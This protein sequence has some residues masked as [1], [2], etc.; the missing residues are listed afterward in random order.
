MSRDFS[1]QV[2]WITGG[3]S[4]IGRA[5]ALELGRRGASVAVSG[6]RTDRLAAVVGELE[7]AGA[8]ALAVACDVCAEDQIEAAVQAVVD[9]FGKLDVAVASA[10]FSVAGKVADLKAA[11]WR[12]QL[13]TNVIGAALTARHA[14]PHLRKTGG[15]I[16]LIG[17]VVSFLCQPKLGAYSA[18]KFALRAIGQTLALE[19]HG[20]GV[21]CTTIHPGFVDS[22]IAKVDNA[23]QFDPTRTDR[24]PQKLMWSADQAAVEIVKALHKR[25]REL[26]FSAHGKVG[27]FFGQHLPGL[28]HLVMTRGK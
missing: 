2:A 10:G 13:D 11:D 26:V 6:R 12:L 22:E 18:S 14:L 1:G 9:H 4:G 15:R 20:T 7:A 5:T 25:K 24:R 19:L 27:A 3:G 16:G 21:S 28:A 8:E 23:G 17:S